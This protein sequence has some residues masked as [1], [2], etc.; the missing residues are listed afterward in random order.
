MFQLVGVVDNTYQILDTYD[1]VVESINEKELRYCLYQLGNISG[2]NLDDKGNIVYAI[3]CL[4]SSDSK[5]N[6]NNIKENIT[7]IKENV[8]DSKE[9]TN[10]NKTDI[11]NIEEKIKDSKTNKNKKETSNVNKLYS[12]L[13][14]EQIKLI[15]KYYLW[16]SQ[17]IFDEGREQRILRVTNNPRA[18]KK[19]AELKV[20]RDK[21]GMWAYA[22]FVD[23]GEQ[24]NDYCTLGHPLRYVH[25]AWDITK[26]DIE[27]AFFGERY[28]KSIDEVINSEHCI[29]FGIDCISDFFEVDKEYTNR[30]RK[31]Q[32]DAIKDMDIL[33]DIYSK[34]E[35][36][37]ALESFQLMSDIMKRVN[38]YNNKCFLLR[39]EVLV[40]RGMAL[41]YHQFIQANLVPPKSLIQEL[42]DSLIGW[43]TH[44][45]TVWQNPDV[46]RLSYVLEKLYKDTEIGEIRETY[47]L[48]SK[49][50]GIRY[51]SMFSRMVRAYLIR[52]FQLDCCG[53]Y[54][55]DANKQ[56]DEGGSNRASWYMLRNIRAFSNCWENTEITEKNLLFINEAMVIAKDMLD[57]YSEYCFITQAYV[58][59]IPEEVRKEFSDIDEAIG[60]SRYRYNKIEGTI[61]EYIIRLR[62]KKE[63]LI[64]NLD[65]VKELIQTLEVQKKEQF[66]VVRKKVLQQDIEFKDGKIYL[67]DYEGIKQDIEYILGGGIELKNNAEFVTKV[68]KSVIKYGSISEK[69]MK[70]VRSAL[71]ELQ[72]EKESGV[73]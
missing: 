14:E 2:V 44:K 62:K 4:K 21:G 59:S 45:F 64:N 71:E 43:K 73:Y 52:V 54:C 19:Q 39:Q 67:D 25:L 1:N 23:C 30:L 46:E 20:L 5:N 72:K 18:L 36:K 50:D 37:E 12:Y 8:I 11:N 41:F 49:A 27:S 9:N 34:G 22:G 63:S 31:A 38:G 7:D 32:R 57:L 16:Y 13:N 53:V 58:E 35:E 28:D 42:R 29:K 33:L 56:K 51:R 10:D 6:Y 61:E 3:D 40:D 24:G 47:L 65:K 26:S 17:R 68:L 55:Y 48:G 60:V 69:Q 66:R 15:K 70:Y